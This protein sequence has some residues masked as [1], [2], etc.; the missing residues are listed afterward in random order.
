[1]TFNAIGIN[2]VRREDTDENSKE[3]QTWGKKEPVKKGK[4]KTVQRASSF[5]KWGSRSPVSK[6]LQ[7]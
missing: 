7:K 3:K 4:K 2:D 5:T 1:M 6:G